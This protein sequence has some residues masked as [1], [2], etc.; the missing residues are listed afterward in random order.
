MSS[1]WGRPASH[2]TDA[3]GL[4]ACPG[5]SSLAPLG[6][7]RLPKR[8]KGRWAGCVGL[9]RRRPCCGRGRGYTGKCVGVRL[10]S[11][12]SSCLVTHLPRVPANLLLL[13][14]LCHRETERERWPSPQGSPEVLKHCLKDTLLESY[15]LP[16]GSSHTHADTLMPTHIPLAHEYLCVHKPWHMYHTSGLK[17]IRA[18]T[19]SDI[20]VSSDTHVSTHISQGTHRHMDQWEVGA[21][22]G[23][24]VPAKGTETE[25]DAET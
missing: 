6:S 11:Q 3:H 2:P 12:L 25:I 10:S 14:C 1:H 8:G 23:D 13:T 22:W 9:G 7:C 20:Q 17:H 15:C 19:N 16:V 4:V 18:H 24:N 5:P 21:T